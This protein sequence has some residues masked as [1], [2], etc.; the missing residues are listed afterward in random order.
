[1]ALSHQSNLTPAS[2]TSP[3]KGYIDAT[4]TG[5]TSLTHSRHGTLAS[6]SSEHSF[7]SPQSSR[8]LYCQRPYMLWPDQLP[9]P[10]AHHGWEG[11]SIAVTDSA[12]SGYQSVCHLTF[13][14]VST[15]LTLSSRP[16]HT[17]GAFLWRLPTPAVQT[18]SQRLPSWPSNFLT[19]SFT[20]SLHR[21]AQCCDEHHL[22]RA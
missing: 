16:A 4:V 13:V 17:S 3:P 11:T 15:S 8:I 21:E 19:T 18:T 1:M 7:S 6:S 12:S 5:S 22:C 2:T 9:R 14:H 10:Y 20:A